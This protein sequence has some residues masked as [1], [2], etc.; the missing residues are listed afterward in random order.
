M[1]SDVVVNGDFTA[2]QIK[3]VYFPN[4]PFIF[5]IFNLQFHL[6]QSN[7]FEKFKA[8]TLSLNY[9]EVKSKDRYIIA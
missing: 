7:R 5:I 6:I 4:D 1:V 3:T 8:V 2:L 9:F